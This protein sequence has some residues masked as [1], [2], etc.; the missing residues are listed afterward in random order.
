MLHPSEKT[1]SMAR[2]FRRDY[3]IIAVL[4]L[5][6]VLII[7]LFGVKYT[8]IYLNRVISES[9]STLNHDANLCVKRLAEAVM[10]NKSQDIARQ[11][12]IYLHNH[13]NQGLGDLQDDPEFLKIALQPVGKSG[14]T[15]IFEAPDGVMHTHPNPKLINKKLSSLAHSS[16]DWWAIV[17]PTLMGVKGIGYYDWKEGDRGENVRKI[18][19]ITPVEIDVDDKILLVAATA[20]L[21]EFIG[22]IRNQDYNVDEVAGRYREFAG[23]QAFTINAIALVVLLAV[24]LGVYLLN[25]RVVLRYI[26]PIEKLSDAAIEIS[27]D[28][29]EFSCPPRLLKRRDEIGALARAFDGMSHHVQALISDLKLRLEEVKQARAARRESE[30]HYRILF[31]SIPIGLYRTS[32]DGQVIDVNTALA[33]MLGFKEDQDWSNYRADQFYMNP[34]QRSKWK[35][36]MANKVGIHVCEEQFRRLDGT[37]VWVEDHAHAVRDENGEV[38]WF[39]GSLKDIS[40]S[41]KAQLALKENERN[42]KAL[43]EESQRAQQVYRSLIHSSADAIVISDLE[44]NTQYVSP[45]FTQW[46]GWTLT[47]L[48]GGPIPFVPEQEK[49]ETEA[50]VKMLVADGEPCQAFSTKRFTK[51]GRVIDVSISASR[52]DDHA[53]KPAGILTIIRDISE[54]K[55]LQAQLQHAERM[56]AIGTLA[57]G[58][59]HDFNNLMMGM[60]GNISLLLFGMDADHPSYDKLKGVENMITS[61]SKLTRHLLGYARKGKYQAQPMSLNELLQETSET[62]GRTRKEMTLHLQLADQINTIEADRIQI[63]QVLM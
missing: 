40:E 57:G 32:P 61:G 5:A 45:V 46:F 6:V 14:F 56:E 59:A 23:R 36:N 4:P 1:D 60:Q 10:L 7:G 52:F 33:G 28:K 47:E 58:I 26:R 37:L 18:V 12:E 22:P 53:Q 3:L 15:S 38:K 41:K 39:E 35:R 31:N 55:K 49:E 63:E 2:S 29:W 20:N 25:H 34:D 54:R 13:P 48:E 43:Y 44:G 30:N 62:F 27:E 16:P 17:E 11:M 21:Q 8:E 24:F 42:Y 50:L 51:Q 9:F 19:T